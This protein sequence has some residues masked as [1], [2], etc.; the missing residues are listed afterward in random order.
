MADG[1]VRLMRIKWEFVCP[2]TICNGFRFFNLSRQNR[3]ILCSKKYISFIR[4]MFCISQSFSHTLN[5]THKTAKEISCDGPEE[6]WKKNAIIMCLSLFSKSFCS[7]PRTF[8]DIPRFSLIIQL[9]SISSVAININLHQPYWKVCLLLHVSIKFSFLCSQ[10][11]ML[12]ACCPT[13]Q[14]KTI[15]WYCPM[16]HMQGN[17]T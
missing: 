1:N 8:A 6:K 2:W 10:L 7:S 16:V 13:Q 11:P 3:R 15:H 5:K 12:I 9:Y 4:L 17:Y 14:Q